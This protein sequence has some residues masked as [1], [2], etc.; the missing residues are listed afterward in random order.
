MC[1]HTTRKNG[2]AGSKQKIKADGQTIRLDARGTTFPLLPVFASSGLKAEAEARG[3]A[4]T[5]ATSKN[6]QFVVD[7]ECGRGGTTTRRDDCFRLM[8]LGD[9]HSSDTTKSG[10]MVKVEKRLD[11]SSTFFPNL[12]RRARSDPSHIQ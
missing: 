4:G 7:D 11:F 8:V 2:R 12:R 10:L 3:K 1:D 6:S 9:R 5:Q